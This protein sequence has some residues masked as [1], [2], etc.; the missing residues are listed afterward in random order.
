MILAVGTQGRPNIHT[1]VEKTDNRL[2]TGYF[3][4]V[5]TLRSLLLNWLIVYIGNWA[6]CLLVGYFLG[7]LTNLFGS[8]QYRIFL[9]EIIVGKL[10]SLG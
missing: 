2:M 7:Y 9:N 1:K 6:G 4:K 5:V 10:E 8:E 3:N